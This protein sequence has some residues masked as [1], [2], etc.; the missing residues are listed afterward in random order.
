MGVG[1][2]REKESPLSS[3][4]PTHTPRL[5]VVALKKHHLEGEDDYTRWVPHEV[6]RR[7]KE[8]REE[9]SKR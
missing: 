5:V 1:A 9:R 4:R 7:G 6:E 8:R 2:E 3:Y